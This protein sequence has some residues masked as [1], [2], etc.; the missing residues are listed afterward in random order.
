[1][2]EFGRYGNTKNNPACTKTGRDISVEGGLYTEEEED[3]PVPYSRHG[4]CGRKATFEEKEEAHV[5]GQELCES[6]GGRPGLPSLRVLMVSVD[7]KQH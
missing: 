1:M 2:S 4:L 5:R 7:I 6:R 3:S